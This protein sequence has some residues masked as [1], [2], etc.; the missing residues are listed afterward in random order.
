MNKKPLV[1]CVDDEK[2]VLDSLV[3]QLM[4]NFGNRF[5]LETAENSEEAWEVIDEVMAEGHPLS[6][7]ISDWLM[8]IEKGDQFLIK[9][10]QRYPQTRLI[11][12]SGHATEDAVD[13]A[14][15]YANLLTFIR[16]PWEKDQLIKAVSEALESVGV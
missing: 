4:N 13:R 14:N 11:M 5:R 10:A 8:P 9:V 12:L 15:T 1:L 3:S 16:K 2:M 6:L 7:I